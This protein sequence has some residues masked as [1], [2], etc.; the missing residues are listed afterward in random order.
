MRNCC[1]IRVLYTLAPPQDL[2]FEAFWWCAVQEAR[3]NTMSPHATDASLSRTCRAKRL[4]QHH[5][6]P[7]RRRV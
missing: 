3:C 1:V 2:S 7:H 6:T 5:V 4:T